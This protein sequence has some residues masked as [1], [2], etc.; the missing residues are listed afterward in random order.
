MM[1]RFERNASLLID[2]SR[3]YQQRELADRNPRISY[4][5]KKIY[6]GYLKKWIE[7][8][9]T[10]YALSAIRSVEVELWLKNL[11]LARDHEA[12]YGTL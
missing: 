8:R 7:P 5:T 9:S 12:K 4:S 3:H 2:L 10:A 1:S 6:A 11:N